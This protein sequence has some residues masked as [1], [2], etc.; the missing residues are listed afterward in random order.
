MFMR[1]SLCGVYLQN[2]SSSAILKWFK[3]SLIFFRDD[4]VRTVRVYM[5]IV[6]IVKKF[7]DLLREPSVLQL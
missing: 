6:A 4:D 7:T 5:S 1:K 2:F 3:L